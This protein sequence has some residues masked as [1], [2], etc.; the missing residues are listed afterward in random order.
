MIIMIA[1]DLHQP[2][3]HDEKNDDLVSRPQAKV[4]LQH[5]EVV[6]LDLF[7]DARQHGHEN[8]EG[9]EPMAHLQVEAH[10]NVRCIL[11]PG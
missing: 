6:G 4:A 1:S 8:I 3:F 7:V 5:E 11:G 10:E 9:P 2:V